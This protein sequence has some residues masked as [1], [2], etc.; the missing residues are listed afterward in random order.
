MSSS[1]Q[2]QDFQDL[3]TDL[4]NRLKNTITD[5]NLLTVAKRLINIALHDIIISDKYEWG[6]RWATIVTQPSYTTGTVA[7]SKGSTT[8][9]GT[10][11]LWNTNNDFGVPNVR[12]GGKIKISSEV[13]EVASVASDTSL[14]LRSTYTR[15][16]ITGGS[17]I[18]FEDEYSPAADFDEI[19]MSQKMIGDI[20]I[21]VIQNDKF[22]RAYVRND[23]LGQPRVATVIDREFGSDTSRVQ[24]IVFSP[25]PNDSWLVRYRYATT[26]LAVDSSGTEKTQLVDDTDEPIIPLK[27]RHVIVLHALKMGYLTTKDDNRYQAVGHEYNE[28]IQRMKVDTG[29]ADPQPMLEIKRPSSVYWGRGARRA[30]RFSTGTEFEELR[31]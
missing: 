12:A 25:S 11:T 9:T 2:V 21:P 3:Y 24:K 6:K 8:V 10:D 29:A 28:L 14:T 15:D 26:Y 22:F 27:Y 4:T 18:Y 1:G 31:I 30:R 23:I 17:Y 19:M 13:Y 5:T 16:D 20:E 7:A